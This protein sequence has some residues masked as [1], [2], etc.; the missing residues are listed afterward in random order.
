MATARKTDRRTL[1]TRQVVKDALLELLQQT[2]YDRINV[3]MLCRQAEIT[4]ATFY[5]HY[6]DLN[7]VLDEVITEALDIA[8][9]SAAEEDSARRGQML[10]EILHNGPQALKGNEQYLAPC[11]RIA[12]HP[13]Y[14][15]LFMDDSLSYYIIRKIYLAE[16]ESS[17]PAI[18]KQCG[19]SAEDADRLFMIVIYGLY[20]VNR[21][22]K[23]EKN[24]AWYRMQYLVSNLYF[25]G[26]EGVKALPE[27]FRKPTK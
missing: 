26:L 13:K 3:T 15:S 10:K 11:Q 5:L 17:V 12:D 8:E 1:Y 4:R 21:S 18:Q 22:M 24:D 23:W 6:E 9:R 27:E 16:K 20:Y 7:Q 14:R 2:A 19:L 25:S